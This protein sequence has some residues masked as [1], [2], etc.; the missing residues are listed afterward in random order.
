M[1]EDPR[2][3]RAAVEVFLLGYFFRFKRGTLKSKPTTF[4]RKEN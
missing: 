2:Q 1:D 4:N 3:P